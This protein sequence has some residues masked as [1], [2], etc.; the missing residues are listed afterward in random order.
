MT[1]RNDGPGTSV[2]QYRWR[3]KWPLGLIPSGGHG[4]AVEANPYCV[5]PEGRL[6]RET[7]RDGRLLIQVN[8]ARV[9]FDVYC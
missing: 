9:T 3:P 8:Y 7:G 2:P 4:N 1:H 6:I 5:R